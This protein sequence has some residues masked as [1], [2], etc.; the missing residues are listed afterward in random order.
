MRIGK[1]I[2]FFLFYF[3]LLVT[4]NVDAL[5]DAS[6]LE[7]L[8]NISLKVDFSYTYK[9]D[10]IKDDSGSYTIPNF[11]I[12]AVN[13]D[14]ELKVLV[15][16]DYYSNDYR[17]FKFNGNREYTLNDFNNNENVVVT[18]KALTNNE[19]SGKTV[20]TKKIDLPFYN[21]FFD[22]EECKEY[23]EF[24]YCKRLLDNSVSSN[25]FDKELE[26]YKKSL[27]ESPTK[28]NVFSKQKYL[29]VGV[30]LIFIIITIVILFIVK[31]KREKEKNSL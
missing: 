27:N 2:K 26:N 17:E 15:I 11:S 31:I 18:F 24:K 29:I 3:L 4:F 22:S 7:R 16:N 25:T 12:T 10:N 13:L 21:S 28:N 5:C 19:C 14:K 23:P 30:I 1:F 6:E 20:Y 8:K 9:I